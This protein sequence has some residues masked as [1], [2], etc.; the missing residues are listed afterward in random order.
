MWQAI[1]PHEGLTATLRFLAT[2]RSYEDFK[3]S[4]IMSPQALGKTIPETC[5]VIYKVLKEYYKVR[6]FNAKNNKRSIV[7]G[8]L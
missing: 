6:A 8:I 5:R 2:G 7:M 1:T 3:F 4:I